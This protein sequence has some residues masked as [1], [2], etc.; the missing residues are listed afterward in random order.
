MRQWRAIQVVH[1]FVSMTC[2]GVDFLLC[3][4]VG[5]KNYRRLLCNR[6]V[7]SAQLGWMLLS[8]CVVVVLVVAFFWALRALG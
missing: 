5:P 3:N 4:G 7:T 1:A 6:L 2:D 8:L